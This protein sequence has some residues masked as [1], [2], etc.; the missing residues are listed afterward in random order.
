MKKQETLYCRLKL[1]D[2]TLRCLQKLADKKNLL[3]VISR[4]ELLKLRRK[5]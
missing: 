4:K 1:D 3:W 2:Y 5:S